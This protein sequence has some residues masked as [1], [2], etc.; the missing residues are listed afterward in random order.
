MHAFSG[1]DKGG[2]GGID[3]IKKPRLL[4]PV[5][6]AAKIVEN[7]YTK[8]KYPA[9]FTKHHSREVRQLAMSFFLFFFLQ[10]IFLMH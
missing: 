5:Y 8:K 7:K 2:K 6:G 1:K 3:F 4:Y 10:S 9:N